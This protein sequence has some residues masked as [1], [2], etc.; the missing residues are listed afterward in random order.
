MLRHQLHNQLNLR[1]NCNGT[2]AS[3]SGFSVSKICAAAS[4]RRADEAARWC[5]VS[6][7]DTKVQFVDRNL[8]YIQVACLK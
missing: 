3:S 4:G 5:G 1:K 2:R 7:V 6:E 8:D